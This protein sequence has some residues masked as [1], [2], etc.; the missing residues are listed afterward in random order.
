MA[1][2]DWAALSGLAPEVLLVLIFCVFVIYSLRL[3]IAWLDKRDQIQSDKEARRD[4]T[5]LS[6]IAEQ[7]K[8]WREFMNTERK[9]QAEGIANLTH[10]ISNLAQLVTSTNS[11]VLQHDAWERA[12]MDQRKLP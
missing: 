8:E 10:E 3:L 6:A 2:I 12:N 1:G 7:N 5:F 9:R 4:Q 11:I